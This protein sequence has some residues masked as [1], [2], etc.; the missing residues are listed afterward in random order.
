MNENVS[1]EPEGSPFFVAL[2]INVFVYLLEKNNKETYIIKSWTYTSQEK[3]NETQKYTSFHFKSRMAAG[4][5]FY[6]WRRDSD[7]LVVQCK[8]KSG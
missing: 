4:V 2:K 1:G 5:R 3:R 6:H 7:D 8:E